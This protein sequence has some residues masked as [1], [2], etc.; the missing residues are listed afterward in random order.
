MEQT[1]HELDLL[2]C[3]V[4][5]AI[6]AA[7]YMHRSRRSSNARVFIGANQCSLPVEGAGSHRQVW[8]RWETSSMLTESHRAEGISF[9]GMTYFSFFCRFGLPNLDMQTLD[10]YLIFQCAEGAR[11][12]FKQHLYP[13]L[14]PSICMCA[15][16]TPGRW[17]ISRFRRG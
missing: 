2:M 17:R 3:Q 13:S 8:R 10:Q 5:G 12:E 14:A 1:H 16:A 7:A 9:D 11:H 15:S 6:P 4:R